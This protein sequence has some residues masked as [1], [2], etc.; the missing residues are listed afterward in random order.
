MR[1]GRAMKKTLLLLAT[2]LST[3]MTF[4]AFAGEW[5]Q[6]EKGWWYQKDDGSYPQDGWLLIDDKMYYFDN[7]GYMAIEGPRINLT[8]TDK[9]IGWEQQEDGKW[10]YRD[11]N[12]YYINK[13]LVDPKTNYEYHFDTFG[14]MNTGL[15]FIDNKWYNFSETGELSYGGEVDENSRSTKDGTVHRYDEPGFFSTVFATFSS[16]KNI[17]GLKLENHRNIPVSVKSRC[18]ITDSDAKIKEIFYHFGNDDIECD[19][20]IP[21]KGTE[22]VYFFAPD[23]HAV[24]FNHKTTKIKVDITMADG[25][26]WF[27]VPIYDVNKFED[28]KLTTFYIEP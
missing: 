24:N 8:K 17:V 25:E 13:W 11:E 9:K 4:S 12:G 14:N 5:K 1:R 3:C 19:M 18:T 6:D 16:E 22:I 10:K 23:L 7:E 28:I 15:C 21:A 26:F 20:V 27:E 2:V